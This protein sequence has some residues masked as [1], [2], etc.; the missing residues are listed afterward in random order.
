MSLQVNVNKG[1][2]PSAQYAAANTIVQRARTTGN[3]NAS[4]ALGVTLPI[5]RI[6]QT[7]LQY[8]RRRHGGQIQFRF[9]TGILQLSL[10]QSIYIANNI[11]NCAQTIWSAHEQDHVS[12]NQQIMDRMD[13][14]IRA[15]HNLQSIL[16]T[17]QW[18]QY[19]RS[20][21]RSVEATIQSTVGSIFRGLTADAVRSRDTTAT[22]TAIRDRIRRQCNP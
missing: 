20:A 21:F 18:R 22:Y 10:R 13:R 17:P 19:T 14:A 2:R 7:Q 11:S 1:T 9:N 16:I 8:E 12:D 6:D 3:P 15:N 5:C 4:Q